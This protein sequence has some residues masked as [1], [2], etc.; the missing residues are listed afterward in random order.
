MGI[1]L[2]DSISMSAPVPL[3]EYEIVSNLNDIPT[4]ILYKGMR[5]RLNSDVDEGK[6]VAWEWD[7]SNWFEVKFGGS[8][9]LETAST[10][11]EINSLP[12]N[13]LVLKGSGNTLGY[14]TPQSL[15]NK[16]YFDRG[17][18]EF[19][20]LDS[21]LNLDPPITENVDI[22]F[23]MKGTYS[24]TSLYFQILLY[25][26]A[27]AEN[28]YWFGLLQHGW[29]TDGGDPDGGLG[30]YS[31]TDYESFVNEEILVPR[32][33]LIDNQEY[34]VRFTYNI[35]TRSATLYLDG[36]EIGTVILPAL[37]V[38]IYRFFQTDGFTYNDDSYIIFESE[39][40]LGLQGVTGTVGG[41]F[42]EE[43]IPGPNANLQAFFYFSSGI[44]AVGGRIDGLYE[45]GG[46]GNNSI[47]DVSID[48]NNVIFGSSSLP[49]E[50]N[51]VDQ[52]G[53]GNSV[54]CDAG[55]AHGC[56]NRVCS[57]G[58]FAHGCCNNA[59]HD[60][61]FS[62]AEGWSTFTC[63]RYS[64]AEGGGSSSI[65]DYSHSEGNSRSFG[66]QSHAEGSSSKACGEYSHSEGS[67]TVAHGNCSH[68]EGY[69]SK[70]CGAY[71]HAEGY[72][73]TS[74][75]SCSHAEGS[76]TC[77]AGKA[78]HAEGY[79]T[80][81]VGEYSHAEGYRTCSEGCFSH[82]E[83]WATTS[84]GCASH[85]SGSNTKSCGRHSFAHGSNTVAIGDGSRAYGSYST[86][87][88]E[89]SEA[90]GCRSV[91]Y[92]GFSYV[93]GCE[94]IVIGDFSSASGK[95]NLVM[96]DVSHANGVGLIIGASQTVTAHDG[97]C[98]F[99]FLTPFAGVSNGD[100]VAIKTNYHTY[101]LTAD[102]YCD[103]VGNSYIC[104]CEDIETLEPD[105][106]FIPDDAII[107]TKSAAG[108]DRPSIVYGKYNAL[109]PVEMPMFSVGCGHSHCNTCRRTESAVCVEQT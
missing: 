52:T 23:R 12:L 90:G 74:I 15:L 86:A 64:H 57:V 98:R 40:T 88:G 49:A 21:T 6:A 62:H 27:T 105:F 85:A 77:S 7:G 29:V 31:S 11:E 73:T 47:R 58:S 16:V 17:F 79:Y 30:I 48:A 28:A 59:W 13:T 20:F 67:S 66:F 18:E 25:D 107:V 83:G 69:F 56:C 103:D 89:Y 24:D 2:L 94:N 78:S 8:A 46:S 45:S 41:S 14:I 34:L 92:G 61:D 22:R 42:F 51:R 54:C 33:E 109:N 102:Q 101:V 37:N 38:D 81:S 4:G 87:Y 3:N 44:L 96:N 72:D 100:K 65:G 5:A 68:V 10:Q 60:A 36:Q 95:E 70:S 53:I 19:R 93:D 84:I 43:E 63:G 80:V 9:V 1:N 71:S 99:S 26:S 76:F 55:A 32:N 82:A 104:T 97:S 35:T 106:V 108:N 39:G 91:T 50:I 75:G